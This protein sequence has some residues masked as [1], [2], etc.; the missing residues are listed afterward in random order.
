VHGVEDELSEGGNTMKRKLSATLVA[1]ALSAFAGAATAQVS[2]GVVKIG[3]MND[4]SGLY[5]DIAGPGSVVAAKM[6]IED[7]QKT[8]KAGL[9]IE[10]ISA[11]HQN[12]PDVGS[13][14]ARQW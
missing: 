11:D 1:A 5:A 9:K 3:V 13:S 10:I 14:I 2:D 6:A 4:M 12:K 8:S 7:F